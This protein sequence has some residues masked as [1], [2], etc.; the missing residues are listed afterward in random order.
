MATI[1][2]QKLKPRII[3]VLA[4]A[5]PVIADDIESNMISS[6]ITGGSN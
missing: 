2:V 3:A 1:S 4:T 6:L 5:I